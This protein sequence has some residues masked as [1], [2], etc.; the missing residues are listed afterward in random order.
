MPDILKA[1]LRARFLFHLVANWPDCGA[2]GSAV[3]C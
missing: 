1:R 3:L 2:N